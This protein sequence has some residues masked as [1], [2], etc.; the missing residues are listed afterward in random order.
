[1]NSPMHNPSEKDQRP[2]QIDKTIKNIDQ[3][4]QVRIAKYKKKNSKVTWFFLYH[5]CLDMY[6]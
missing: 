5:D 4:T 6:L 3:V 2:V 1:M